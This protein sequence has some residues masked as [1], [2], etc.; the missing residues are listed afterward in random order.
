MNEIERIASY[1]RSCRD[2]NIDCTVTIDKSKTHIILNAL[3]KQIP[4]TNC[5]IKKKVPYTHNLGRLLRFLLGCMKQMLNV[6]EE[7]LTV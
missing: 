7:F 1:I 6:A 4:K 5:K 3:E 2:A